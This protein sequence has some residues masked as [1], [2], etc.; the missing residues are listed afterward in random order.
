MVGSKRILRRA[1]LIISDTVL[2]VGLLWLLGLCIFRP[3]SLLSLGV[4]V[5]ILLRRRQR[6]RAFGR[7]ATL[8]LGLICGVLT[9]NV[10]SGPREATWQKPWARAP[11]FRQVGDKLVIRN[12]RDFRYRS[13][14]DYDVQYRTEV[15]D[16]NKLTGVDFGECHWDGMEAICHT[17]LSFNFEDGQHLVVSAE[18]RLPEGEEQN[19]LGGI[20]KRYGMLY[21]FG[22]EE[23]IYALRTNYRHED[24]TLFPLKATPE[25]ARALL[26]RYV[27]LARETEE[28]QLPYNTITD[29][30][31]SGLV[32][33]FAELAPNM[34]AGYRLLPLHNASISKLL[35]KHGA[36]RTREGESWEALSQRCYLGY[37]I[38]KNAPANYSQAIRAKRGD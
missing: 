28:R 25:Q 29:N 32:R 37:D 14:D 34:P 1:G 24:L 9:Y 22:T 19:A 38:A 17:M 4:L 8:W 26:L 16:L 15:Y 27:E 5:A 6:G 31:S 12:L 7:R 3:E 21:V 10:L 11:Q 2:A 13:E 33:I 35:Y 30:C 18:T 36:L 23:D 20:Y